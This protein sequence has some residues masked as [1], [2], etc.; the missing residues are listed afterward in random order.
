MPGSPP[1]PVP[2]T[3]S[4]PTA[5]SP[6]PPSQNRS[7]A[8]RRCTLPPCLRNLH[9]NIQFSRFVSTRSIFYENTHT[10]I[11]MQHV[12]NKQERKVC[13]ACQAL[14]EKVND[15]RAKCGHV[16]NAK[17]WQRWITVEVLNGHSKFPDDLSTIHVESESYVDR[18][19]LGG[20]FDILLDWKLYL[21][22]WQLLTAFCDSLIIRSKYYI[23]FRMIDF[24]R[25]FLSFE[26][27]IIPKVIAVLIYLSLVLYV[28]R[29]IYWWIVICWLN[30]NIEEY[31]VNILLFS[32]HVFRRANIK[33]ESCIRYRICYT[34]SASIEY[35]SSISSVIFFWFISNR[36]SLWNPEYFFTQ[37]WFRKQTD[38]ENIF[39]QCMKH[40]GILK[41]V[42]HQQ[43]CIKH[44]RN[45][46]KWKCSIL[47]KL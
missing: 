8:L 41:V 6:P 9:R 20:R 4:C 28:I 17:I 19:E 35:W 44:S 2:G 15:R 26:L 22:A 31:I 21:S 46:F 11:R 10:H 47:M 14:C 25:H 3:N 18:S 42:I 30:S 39:K 12:E 37:R 16:K 33:M 38:I 5:N 7:A 43:K 45:Y 1:L 32:F 27:L 40:E 36:S 24:C 13:T 23:F 29:K 34:E